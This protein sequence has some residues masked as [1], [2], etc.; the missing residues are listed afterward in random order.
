MAKPKRSWAIGPLCAVLI[1]LGGSPSAGFE[2]L[3]IRLFEPRDTARDYAVTF[4][5]GADAQPLLKSLQSVSALW[6]QR[7]AN[8]DDGATLLAIA[9]ADYRAILAAL[10]AQGYYSPSISIRLDGRE[11]AEI[12]FTQT[13]AIPAEVIVQVDPGAA[14]AF[15]QVDVGPIAPP[16]LRRN[17]RV[18]SPDS[19]GLIRGAPAYASSIG[20]AADLAVDAWR[21][22]GHPLA[23]VADR[24]IIADHA[25]ARMDVQ[26]RIDP[27]PVAN[28]GTV[29]VQGEQRMQAEFLAF[30]ARLPQGRVFD[31]DDLVRINARLRRLGVFGAI[32][33]H[34]A[35]ALDADGN[36]PIMIE[37][38][39]QP[40]R[41]I[42][43]G[44]TASSIDGFG[45]EAYWLHRN[46]FGHAERLRFAGS[47]S[48]V[49][50][51]VGFDLADYTL[52]AAFTRPGVILPDMDFQL[53]LKAGRETTLGSVT[54]FGEIQGGLVYQTGQFSASALGFFGFDAVTSGLDSQR[55]TLA[56][57]HLSGTYDGRDDS[58]DPHRGMYLGAT[59]SPLWEFEFGNA[60]L[61][62]MLEGRG[63]WAFGADEQFVL[64]AR[65]RVGSLMGFAPE[66]APSSLLYLSGG[67]NSVRG[68]GYDSRGIG[69]GTDLTGGLSLINL[70]LEARWVITNTI[71]LVAF[72]D[73][74]SVGSTA[75][76]GE[77]GDWHRGIG[78][79]LRYQ[80]GLGP[81]RLDVARGLDLGPDDP[82]I[83]IYL[84]LG[85]AF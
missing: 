65:A 41:R 81:L 27:G 23:R 75:M 52:S 12:P 56:G 10:Y 3:G 11:A 78:L 26:L 46:L 54:T 15:G 85:Q 58:L 29:T 44:L 53:E 38:A 17:D 80:T 45:A 24:R 13:V 79:G 70:S 77:T 64:A 50:P 74:G 61:S 42:S 62:A 51:T 6:A 69:T 59:L 43:V 72:F 48:G 30:M 71:G 84:G 22:Q 49:G 7:R 40:L 73:A 19:T 20:A 83:A 39:E 82:G 33:I 66:Q 67:G 2:I 9:N 57:L 34:E 63:Y 76:P 8:L 68:Y 36:L 4:Q 47:V 21:Q 35:A 37:V 32:H 14:F 31:P 60:G 18:A 1:A 16:A 55:F 25:T 5:L 28:F